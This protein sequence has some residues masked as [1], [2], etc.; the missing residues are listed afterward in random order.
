MLDRERVL[1][2]LD[3]L[4]RY[5]AELRQVIP[6]NFNEYGTVAVKRACERLLQISIETVMD[7]CALLLEEDFRRTP[8]GPR[9][10]GRGSTAGTQSKNK[11]SEP[12][13]SVD[14][15]FRPTVE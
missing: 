6:S 12:G 2:K 13:L 10:Q 8:G 11:S 4:D 1:A 14:T 15:P 9:G 5:L 3:D 7:V